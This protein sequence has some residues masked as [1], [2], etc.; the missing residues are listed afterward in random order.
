MKFKN[1]MKKIIIDATSLR[2]R[3]TGIERYA[4][5]LIPRVVDLLSSNCIVEILYCDNLNWYKNIKSDLENVNFTRMPNC[6]RIVRDQFIMPLFFWGAKYDLVWFPLFPPS[7]LL[8]FARCG[9]AKIV[10]TIFDGVIWNQRDKISF[11]NKYYYSV[12]EKLNINSYDAIHTI[13]NFS[14]AEIGNALGDDSKLIISGIGVNNFGLNCGSN[15]FVCKELNQ[16]LFV[17]TIEPRKN[18]NF[19]IDVISRVR[20]KIPDVK[21]LIVGRFGWGSEDI[22]KKVQGLD[23]NSSIEFLG[24]VSD[25]KLN[26][27]FASS[28]AFVF[29]SLS[30][31]FGLPPVEAMTAGCPVISSNAGA[32]IETVGDG[33]VLLSPHDFDGWVNAILKV[34]QDVDFRESLIL[35]GHNNAS[36]YSWDKVAKRIVCDFSNRVFS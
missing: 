24:V 12:E 11:A 15:G 19:L 9:G 18:L 13:S 1:S 4:T 16:L 34:L 2:G 6:N 23:L 5:E 31:G 29:P 32:L 22:L 26:Q 14:K 21:L 25:D 36:K 35:R 3:L 33:G 20:E 10:R 8:M 28:T 7:P 30:E 27:L 17:G